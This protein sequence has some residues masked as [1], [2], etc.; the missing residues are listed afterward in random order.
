MNIF[1]RIF[2]FFFP[3]KKEPLSSVPVVGSVDKIKEV[4]PNEPIGILADPIQKKDVVL[5]FHTL[6]EAKQGLSNEWN[7]PKRRNIKSIS[8]KRI[9]RDYNRIKKIYKIINEFKAA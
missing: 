5:V 6:K 2:R 9:P 1:L 7:K 4:V 3:Q 8:D